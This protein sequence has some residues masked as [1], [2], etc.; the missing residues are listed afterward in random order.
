MSECKSDQEL[1][2]AHYHEVKET[3]AAPAAPQH[4]SLADGVRRLAYASLGLLSVMSD[5]VETFYEK[6]V[7]RGEQR[8]NEARA[9]TRERQVA[10][11]PRRTTAGVGQPVAAVLDRSGLVTKS[12]MDALSARVDALSHEIDVVAEQRRTR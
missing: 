8:A 5:E 3:K 2:M 9:S 1:N 6:C 7:T 12:D 4:V 10:R 11:R